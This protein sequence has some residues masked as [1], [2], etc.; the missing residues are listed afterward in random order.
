MEVVVA[1]VVAESCF[2][3]FFFLEVMMQYRNF[4]SARISS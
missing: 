1:E 3:S 2:C 4:M